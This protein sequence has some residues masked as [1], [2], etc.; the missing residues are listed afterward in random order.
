MFASCE[1][2]L[3]KELLIRILNHVDVDTAGWVVNV[4]GGNGPMREKIKQW[5]E[6]GKREHVVLLTD[7]DTARCA[8]GLIAAWCGRRPKPVGL[9]LRV[10]VRSAESWVLADRIGFA[11]FLDVSQSLLPRQ[12]DTEPS[13]KQRLLQLAEKSPKRELRADIVVRRHGQPRQATNYNAALG[14]FVAKR[15]NVSRAAKASP[16]LARTIH[17]LAAS[18]RARP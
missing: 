11:Q 15:W 2:D 17:R 1:D 7:L 18:L 6:V 8:S 10:A 9:H 16:S 5:G 3:G 4:A 12:P 13:P 14:P